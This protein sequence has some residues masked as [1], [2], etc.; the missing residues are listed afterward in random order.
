MK[1][2]VAD[3]VLDV[4]SPIGKSDNRLTGY[5]S[6][7]IIRDQA[8][9]DALPVGFTQFGRTPK[10]GDI[11]FEDINGTDFAEGPDGII[12]DFDRTI[13][14]ENTVP[15][16][17]YGIKGGFTWR[18]LSLDLLFQGVAKYDK[19]VRTI[20]TGGA[21]VFQIDG[22]PYFELWTDAYSAN[23]PGGAYP[24]IEGWGRPELGH[25]ASSFWNRSGAYIRLKNVSLSYRLPESITTRFGVENMSVFVN[26]SNLFVINR[27]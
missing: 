9:L 16:I 2:P 15:R 17:N 21:G 5:V 23:N 24:R 8:T 19:F 25:G 13:I 14:S 11:L 6:K 26:G 22:R 4:F 12:N 18:G 3:G 20:N 27:I 10:L 7:G 1:F